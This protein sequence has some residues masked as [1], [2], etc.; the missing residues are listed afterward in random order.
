MVQEASQAI[1]FNAAYTITYFI[2]VIS[3]NNAC[4]NAAYAKVL[5][6]S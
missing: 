2:P 3:N 6:T 1:Q 4:H 5:A